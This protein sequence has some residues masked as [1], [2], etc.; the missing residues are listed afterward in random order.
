MAMTYVEHNMLSIFYIHFL[1]INENI[2]ICYSFYKN[3]EKFYTFSV[4]FICADGNLV[5]A[6]TDRPLLE[7]FVMIARSQAIWP[8]VEDVTL[9][10]L[11]QQVLDNKAMLIEPGNRVCCAWIDSHLPL[12]MAYSNQYRVAILWLQLILTSFSPVR[13]IL[14]DFRE[15]KTNK[16]A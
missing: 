2:C 4:W 5:A 6:M 3:S 13:K 15:S 7:R 8:S 12:D 1:L 11:V 10:F 16:T 14:V 9:P